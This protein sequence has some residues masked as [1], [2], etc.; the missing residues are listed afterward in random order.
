MKIPSFLDTLLAGFNVKI[1][2]RTSFEKLQQD[3]STAQNL[4]Q[5]RDQLNIWHDTEIATLEA[6]SNALHESLTAAL[7]TKASHIS[8]EEKEYVHGRLNALEKIQRQLLIGQIFNH[9]QL[10]DRLE[11]IA[12]S[13]LPTSC[14]LCGQN[15]PE[16]L[17]T[18]Q[19][20]CIFQG[21]R[22]LRHQCPHCDVIFGPEKMFQ[23][24]S[25]DLAEEY[26]RHY[27]VFHESDCT[28]LE[29]RSFYDLNPRKDGIYLNY[30]GGV[31]SR[32][33]PELRAEGWNV[34]NYEPY[35][36]EEDE[37][38]I[39]NREQ[40]AGMRFDGIFSHD[41]VEHLRTPVKELSFM[42]S[43]LK[44]DGL[45][46]HVTGCWEYIYEY[47]RFHLYFFVGRSREIL[48]KKAGLR[49]ISYNTDIPSGYYSCLFTHDMPHGLNVTDV[50]SEPEFKAICSQADD[51][52]LDYAEQLV[53]L[54]TFFKKS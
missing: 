33:V 4:L 7:E 13:S 41:L 28:N 45:M 11:K 25:L 53:Q 19:T 1:T 46:N 34:L 14:P 20:D 23:L 52:P 42:K 21:G 32:A 47:T 16:T 5:L 48:A 30:G 2:H 15:L 17:K 36:P 10:I 3:A 22:L 6:K 8:T 29:K 18:F 50:S 44:P 54:N 12:P 37:G 26:A 38:L 24:S 49:L 40:L 31:W 35:S 51:G 27:Q 39:R 43:L 9:W